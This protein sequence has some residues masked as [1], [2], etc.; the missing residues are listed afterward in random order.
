MGYFPPLVL[1]ILRTLHGA[2]LTLIR[3]TRHFAPRLRKFG[4]RLLRMPGNLRRR[5]GHFPPLFRSV[6]WGAVLD[7][8][9][10]IRARRSL[11]ALPEVPRSTRIL[12]GRT[13]LLERPR[14]FAP[15]S[16]MARRRHLLVIAMLSETRQGQR[17]RQH[18][19][20]DRRHGR[21]GLAL[22]NLPLT[23][24]RLRILLVI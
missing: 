18:Q 5:M 13:P 17:H 3:W 19:A 20:G 12:A 7:S 8:G 23:P 6:G 15:G 24:R 2:G 16:F 22:H 14:S 10:G 21:H 11:S 9:L 4:N 1:P